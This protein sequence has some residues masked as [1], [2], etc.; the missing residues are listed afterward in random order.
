ML[1]SAAQ[2]PA[3]SGLS[4]SLPFTNLQAI[5]KHVR[6]IVRCTNITAFLSCASIDVV[7]FPWPRRT[8][9]IRKSVAARK[10]AVHEA[11]CCEPVDY[12]RQNKMRSTVRVYSP[13]LNNDH[14]HPIITT[15]RTRFQSSAIY[16][17]RLQI[18][19]RAIVC[20]INSPCRT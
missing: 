1:Q 10:R 5:L 12:H 6:T 15:S 16:S 20:D 8:W 7:Q 18:M 2:S 14:H 9:R 4:L 19:R 11:T 13:H 17:T 3:R